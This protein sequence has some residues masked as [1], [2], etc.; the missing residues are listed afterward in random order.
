M[1]KEAF[2]YSE[3]DKLQHQ[4]DLLD[5]ARR[6]SFE[7]YKLFINNCII[8]LSGIVEMCENMQ[9]GNVSHSRANVRY[10]AQNL[11][12]KARELNNV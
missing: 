4:K 9:P 7:K 10:L 1:D 3:F 2:P 8:D 6:E 11:L 5:A 12:T